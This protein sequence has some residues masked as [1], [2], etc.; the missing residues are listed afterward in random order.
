MDGF[1]FY[2]SLPTSQVN[3]RNPKKYDNTIPKD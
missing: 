1:C 2:N 3:L